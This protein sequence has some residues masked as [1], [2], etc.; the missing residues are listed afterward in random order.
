MFI[1]KKKAA[2]FGEQIKKAQYARILK[3]L[4]DIHGLEIKDSH[5]DVDYAATCAAIKTK[6]R[7]TLD[8]IADLDKGND[9]EN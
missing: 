4:K 1:K 5:G 8:F 3:S 7:L 6:A 2:D 9:D